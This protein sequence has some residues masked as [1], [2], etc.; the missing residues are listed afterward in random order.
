MQIKIDYAKNLDDDAKKR[1]LFIYQEFLIFF[2]EKK[3][4]NESDIKLAKQ[5]LQY[6]NKHAD[7]LDSKE[8]NEYKTILKRLEND[9]PQIFH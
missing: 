9:Y 8:L 7:A 1:F 6:L 2:S 3:E 5:F 4:L